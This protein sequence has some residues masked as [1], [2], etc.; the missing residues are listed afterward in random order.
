MRD[1]D[2]RSRLRAEL[3]ALFAHDAGDTRIVDE[4]G[5]CQ[6]AV[7]VDVAVIN[8]KLHGYEIKSERD[9]LERLP[10]QQAAYSRVFD[11]MTIVVGHSHAAKAREAIPPWWEVQVA[12]AVFGGGVTL[13]VVR[14]GSENPC[15]EADALVQLLWRNEA[16][17]L[18]E[19]SGG[20]EGMRS[21]PRKAIWQRLTQALTL[22]E[23]QA[24]VRATLKARRGWRGPEG[25]Q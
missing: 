17:Q 14:R 5:V 4:L 9:T 3:Q 2:I 7:R 24:A 12:D 25:S 21:K 11:R 13:D 16:L 10:T 8:G 18:L 15:V 22:H 19:L 6:G 20:A 1:R 23:L